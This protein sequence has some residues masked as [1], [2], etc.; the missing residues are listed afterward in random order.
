MRPQGARARGGGRKKSSAKNR[1]L[2]N[3]V[4]NMAQL[5]PQQKQ[6]AE[7]VEGPMLVVAGAGS[8][9]TRTITARIQHLLSIGVPASEILA[10]TFTNKAA[11]E[12][13]ERVHTLT[14]SVVLTTTFHSLGA[15]IL[16]AS[17]TA[18][19]FTTQFTIF[20]EDESEKILKDCLKELN[21]VGEDL[22][23]VR[24]AISHFKNQLIDPKDQTEIQA[25]YQKKLKAANAVD[26]DD[27]LYLPVQ[28]FK[29]HPDVL[30][31]YQ[32]KWSFI[33]IDEYQDTNTAQYQ[34]IRLLSAKHNNVFAVGDPDQ[35]I[36]SWRG[37]NIDN[38]LNF[39]RDFIGAQSITLEQNYRSTNT[40]LQA[41]NAL[42]EH[43]EGRTSKDLWSE[44]GVGEKIGVQICNRDREEP[45]FVIQRIHH[46]LRAQSISLKDCV[47]FYRT[48]FQSRLFED[49]LLK[50]RIPYVIIGGVSFYQRK[51]IKDVLS[52]LRLAAGSGD[53]VAFGRTLN[54]PKRGIGAASLEK[55]KSCA[56]AISQDCITTARLITQGQVACKLSA[57]QLENLRDYVTIIDSLREMI[58]SHV[59]LEEIVSLTI[60]MIRYEE[61]L[62]ED[63][64][65]AQD[66]KE[67][68]HE[69]IA[70]T[71]DWGEEAGL[72]ALTQFLE[73]LTLKSSLDDLTHSQDCIRLMSLHNGKGLEFELTFLVGMEE[74]LFPHAN[75]R[76]SQEL[77]E[78]ERRLC[79]V[80]MT[81]AKKFLYLSACRDRFLWGGSRRMRPSR[82]LK[83]IPSQFL[84]SF[85]G[86]DDTEDS[87]GFEVGDCVKHKSFGE[88]IIRKIYQT[89]LGTTYDIF[90]E[91][92]DTE[93][94]L[95]AK[96]A[97]L[98]KSVHRA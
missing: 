26:F 89:S 63:P 23:K 21:L 86:D 87:E 12:M 57:K 48:N 4:H 84:K 55:I 66:R 65:T 19:G 31:E 47:I 36:Y 73:E 3:I 72:N 38:I 91:E 34:F 20:D 6:A 7:H 75:A 82:F 5:N 8:G 9:K 45:E 51:E 61:Y 13:R 98:V 39:S 17:I 52:F 71:T 14:Q 95:I 37:A 10:V 44:L 35:S 90:F 69:L 70:K 11:E 85:D 76:E 93:R 54:I 33:L 74:D 88:G 97:K 24:Q 2:R 46:H 78:E 80:G 64:E 83:E 18:L 30:A 94:T 16:R 43:N 50:S 15:R 96:F 1:V 42:I 77:L 58:K 53:S 92:S 60:K 40:I 32:K 79:Y 27:L 41:A 67:N 49:A 56:E 59:S 68:V 81:R 28:L 62:K 22:K 25:L 29:N